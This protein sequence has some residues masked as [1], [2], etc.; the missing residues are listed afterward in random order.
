MSWICCSIWLP[1]LFTA[2]LIERLRLH[3]L[4]R[5]HE[6]RFII[7]GGNMTFGWKILNIHFQR[8]NLL[9]GRMRE[10]SDSE[11]YFCQ[12]LFDF[13]VYFLS[14]RSP[15]FS[16]VHWRKL[17]L[18]FFYLKNFVS[19]FF[20]SFAEASTMVFRK[21]VYLVEI[22]L[23]ILKNSFHKYLMHFVFYTDIKQFFIIAHISTAEF[24]E[25]TY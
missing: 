16:F 1:I 25:S 21:K 12:L 8:F 22:K 18:F 19:R 24:N 4:Q 10:S 14:L 2:C 3:T 11:T 17:K 7:I 23:I 6:T 5:D 13:R 15:N 9:T 20:I